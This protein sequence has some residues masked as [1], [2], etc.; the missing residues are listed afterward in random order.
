[1]A[2]VTAG[3]PPL[4]ELPAI[5]DA[6]A[7]GG[8][9]VIEVGIPFSDPFGEGPT[10]Q[11]SSQRALD[12]GA[13]PRAI[14]EAIGKARLRVPTVTMGYYNPILRHGLVRYAEECVA[15]GVSGTIVSD[16]VPDEAE[17]WNA[18]SAAAGIDTIFLVAPTSTDARIREGSGTFD[19]LRLRGLPDGG[20]GRGERRAHRR[21]GTRSEGSSGPDGSPGV[22]RLRYLDAGTRPHG[23]RGRRRGGGRERAGEPK[24]HREWN[25]G[26]G[27]AAIVDF[28]RSLKAA[29][30]GS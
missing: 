26:K 3:D 16:L 25:G 6:L 1:M 7:E 14:L 20:H 15:V 10:I 30:K 17:A 4:E 21:D 18:A 5:L 9:D 27:R 8:A 12:A 24:I 28:V 22:R 11:A 23:V 29:T 2:F 13:T 19:R